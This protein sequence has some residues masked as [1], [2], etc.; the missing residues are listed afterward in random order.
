MNMHMT[1]MFHKRALK[2]QIQQKNLQIVGQIMF[3]LLFC[4]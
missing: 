4:T 2:G 1:K 3:S